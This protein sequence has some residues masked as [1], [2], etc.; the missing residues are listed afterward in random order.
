[1]Q[2]DFIP[3]ASADTFSSVGAHGIQALF[4]FFDGSKANGTLGLLHLVTEV[5]S[6]VQGSTCRSILGKTE[7]KIPPSAGKKFNV[8]M[9]LP[10]IQFI[11]S[12]KIQ[13]DNMSNRSHA[14]HFLPG[15]SFDFRDVHLA[16]VW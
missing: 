11:R 12:C 3:P 1:M 16:L 6:V 9:R 13:L 5:S 7:C 4:S 14:L 8:W 2:W 15:M 10:L